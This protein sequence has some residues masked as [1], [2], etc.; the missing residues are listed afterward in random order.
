MN[1]KGPEMDEN[2]KSAA[3]SFMHRATASVPWTFPSLP[4]VTANI[5]S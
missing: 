5:S 1:V 4:C 2:P 3:R